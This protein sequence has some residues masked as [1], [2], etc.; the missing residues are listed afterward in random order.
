MDLCPLSLRDL[1]VSVIAF[2][3]CTVAAFDRNKYV[4]RARDE[5]VYHILR[6]GNNLQARLNIWG[7]SQGPTLFITVKGLSIP[8]E[9]ASA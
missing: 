3:V 7:A 4:Y 9:W 6:A 1:P 2:L 8:V 5:G